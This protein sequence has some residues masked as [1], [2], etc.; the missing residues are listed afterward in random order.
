MKCN[1]YLHCVNHSMDDDQVADGLI[2]RLES[3]L[4]IIEEIIQ[5]LHATAYNEEI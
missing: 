1:I 2:T 4:A 3:T 5:L